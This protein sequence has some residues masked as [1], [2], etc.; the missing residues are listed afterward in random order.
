M[1]PE[2]PC[3]GAHDSRLAD[4]NPC[5]ETEPRPSSATSVI[6]AERKARKGGQSGSSIPRGGTSWLQMLESQLKPSVAE[7]KSP[8]EQSR[9]LILVY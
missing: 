4:K 5:A 7:I 1:F 6:P 2:T 3:R 8:T 9:L